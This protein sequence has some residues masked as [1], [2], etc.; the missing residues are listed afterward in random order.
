MTSTNPLYSILV[1]PRCRGEL[2]HESERI[3]CGACKAVYPILYGIP[4]FRPPGADSVYYDDPAT[5]Q[6]VAAQFDKLSQVEIENAMF[7]AGDAFQVAYRK[8]AEQ[9]SDDHW[10]EAVDLAG[11]VPVETLAA[12]LDIGCGLGGNVVSLAKKFERAYS[13]D[14]SYKPL[15][16][17]KKRLEERGLASRALVLAA[18]AE[19]LPFRDG[20]FDF[21]TAINVIEHVSDQPLT[22]HEMHRVL[23]SGGAAF[24]DSPNRFTLLPEPHV[25]LWG[26]S[27]LP[28]NWADPYVRFRNGTGYKGKR[29]LSILELRRFLQKDFHADFQIGVPSFEARDY[30]PDGALKK[31]ARAAFNGL[32]RKTPGVSHALYPFAPTYNVLARKR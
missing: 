12:A 13:I 31:M 26:V 14:I 23:H 20:A 4:D 7:G 11:G 17:A 16:V 29:L 3:V 2:N 32:L 9:R 21:V 19:A 28:R 6:S 24:F 5:V 30:Y 8:A 27:Y 1:C 22:L 15:L 18:S 25:K 10:Q